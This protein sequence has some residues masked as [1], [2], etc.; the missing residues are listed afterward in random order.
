MLTPSPTLIEMPTKQFFC[1]DTNLFNQSM[2]LKVTIYR[3]WP[4]VYKTRN[5]S[6]DHRRKLQLPPEPCH[7]CKTLPSLHSIFP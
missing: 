4:V 1:A 2:N 7:R 5:L 6:V 3:K